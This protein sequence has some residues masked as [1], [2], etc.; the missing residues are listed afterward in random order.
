MSAFVVIEGKALYFLT[1]K[2]SDEAKKIKSN[3]TTQQGAGVG[4]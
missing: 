4:R 1:K 3:R 2:D